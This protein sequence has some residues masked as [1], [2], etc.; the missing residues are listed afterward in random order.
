[1]PIERIA[2]PL[3]NQSRS[4]FGLV[5]IFAIGLA[6]RQQQQAQHQG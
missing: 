4:A 5:A 1:L 2:R 6:T 3:V